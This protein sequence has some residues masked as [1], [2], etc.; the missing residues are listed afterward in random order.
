MKEGLENIDK[1]VKQAFDGFEANV[2]PSVWGNIQSSIASSAGSVPA[3]TSVVG[4][5]LAIKIVA[6]VLAVSSIATGAYFIVNDAENK[7]NTI[8]EANIEEPNVF[9]EDSEEENKSIE[10]IEE[11]KTIKP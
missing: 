1:I 2:D 9:V 7:E 5:S 4:K 3:A 11:A 10:S 8:A 6:G